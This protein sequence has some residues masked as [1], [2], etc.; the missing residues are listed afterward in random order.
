MT[1]VVFR[2]EDGGSMFLRNVGTHPQVHTALRPRRPPLMLQR[3]LVILIHGASNCYNT[4]LVSLHSAFSR[5][6]LL[7]VLHT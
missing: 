3:Y 5:N 6:K 4:P 7:T 1:M 2:A